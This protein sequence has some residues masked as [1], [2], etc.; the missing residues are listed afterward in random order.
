MP[1]FLRM[2]QYTFRVLLLG[3]VLAALQVCILVK[4]VFFAIA[5]KRSAAQGASND[6]PMFAEPV[7]K[8][9]LFS[10]RNVIRFL[11]S[12]VLSVG[13]LF[14]G[15]QALLH[16]RAMLHAY[17]HALTSADTAMDELTGRSEF[18]GL[19]AGKHGDYFP[20]N[21]KWNYVSTRLRGKLIADTDMK[22]SELADYR[23]LKQISFVVQPSEAGCVLLNVPYAVF[24]GVEVYR[25]RT[26]YSNRALKITAQRDNGGKQVRLDVAGDGNESKIILSYKNAPDFQAYLEETAFGVLVLKGDVTA[27]NLKKERAGKYS[28]EVTAGE[29]GGVLELPSYYYKG[30]TLTLATADGRRISVLPVHGRNGFVEA[31]I[32]ESGT[33][34]VEF[35]A[36]Y[37]TAATVLTTVG[38][39]AFVGAVAW[40]VFYK[41]KKGVLTEA[42]RTSDGE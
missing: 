30:Y 24:E 40:C 23:A 38:A 36:P 18:Y 41:Q 13:L 17:D 2:I 21:C 42:E 12:L 27:T 8:Q 14:C 10:K 15:P 4:E 1:N 34:Y 39:V 31:E 26:T 25:F 6:A 9:K 3:G 35:S 29:N 22:L 5:E 37:L 19:G 32:T 20:N 28:L 33:L 16:N 11:P 7:R